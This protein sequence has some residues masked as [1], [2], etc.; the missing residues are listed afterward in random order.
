MITEIPATFFLAVTFGLFW[1]I[2]RG[3]NYDENPVWGN[4]LASGMNIVFC[5]LFAIWFYQGNIVITDVQISSIFS[6]PNWG[7]TSIQDQA[8]ISTNLYILGEGGTGMYVVSPIDGVGPGVYQTNASAQ[9]Y[10][11]EIYYVQ[12]QDVGLSFVFTMLAI[13]SGFLFSWFSWNAKLLL[14]DA[15]AYNREHP[16]E[17]DIS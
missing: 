6:I 1:Y 7:N 12:L 3:L 2:F 17:D 16:E 9:V 14:E 13:I 15:A 5:G 8:N 11:H 10:H 4:V